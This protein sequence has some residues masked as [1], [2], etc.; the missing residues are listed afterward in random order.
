[1]S[2]RKNAVVLISGRGS[3]MKSLLEN[4]NT[5]QIICVLSNRPEARGLETARGLGIKT[6]A[7]ER[8]D[9]AAVQQ[10]KA[11][12]Y[13]AVRELRPDLIFL[14][15]YM[16]IIESEFV[17]EFSDRLVNIHPSILP[18]LPGLHTHERAI[19]EGRNEHGCSVHF[20]DAGVD[21]GP[22]IA[23]AK[24]NVDTHDTAD[25]L[26]EKV[27]KLEHKIFPWAA[28][29]LAAGDIWLEKRVVHSTK[30]VAA[31]ACEHGFILPQHQ[32]DTVR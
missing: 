14:A 10:Q 11:A 12:I 31:E 28:N 15:G 21:T 19:S 1:M 18:D 30:A 29:A 7:F 20:V 6:I 9:F 17:E 3:N 26:A 4:Q 16:Q 13:A 25:S 5:F 32:Q 23:Q 8:K 22:V 27:L 24:C 2:E